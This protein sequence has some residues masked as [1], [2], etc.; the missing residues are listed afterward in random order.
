MV[1]DIQ[2]IALPDPLPQGFIGSKAGRLPERLLK[3]GQYVWAERQ[4]LARWHVEVQQGLQA[5]RGIAREP[6]A[7]GIA[8]DTQQLGHILARLGLP[9]G[10]Q[11]EH[12]QPCSFTPVTLT[13]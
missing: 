5:T 6:M 4:G 12:L 1:V 8:V 3:G 2:V 13:V 9:A 10:Q 7:D 11:V